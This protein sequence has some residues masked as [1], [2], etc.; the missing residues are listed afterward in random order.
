M[1]RFKRIEKQMEQSK[2]QIA[3]VQRRFE[4][5][6][7]SPEEVFPQCMKALEKIGEAIQEA[8]RQN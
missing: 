5:G 8:K 1:D 6:S 7:I 2:V 3:D 4:E